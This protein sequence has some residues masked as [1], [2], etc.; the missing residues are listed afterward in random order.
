MLSPWDWETGSVRLGVGEREAAAMSKQIELRSLAL[1]RL[2][3]R[4]TGED[5]ERNHYGSGHV[6]IYYLECLVL[7]R[8]KGALM[9]GIAS[10][11]SGISSFPVVLV[12][13]GKV[14][15]GIGGARYRGFTIHLRATTNPSAAS[16]ILLDCLVRF[17][18]KPNKTESGGSVGQE[19]RIALTNQS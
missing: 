6:A 19:E 13:E 5:D 10:M 12:H 14:L 11:M 4:R 17:Y 7:K 16:L 2:N 15:A 18:D 8:L 9:Y 3:V 1:P